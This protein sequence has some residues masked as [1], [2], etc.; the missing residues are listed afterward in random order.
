GVQNINRIKYKEK[1]T[2]KLGNDIEEVVELVR[3][4][5]VLGSRFELILKDTFYVPSFGR[6]LISLSCLD[7]H[8]FIF[9]FGETKINLMLNSQIIGYGSL[10]DR[11]YKFDLF[12]LTISDN[13]VV[14]FYAKINET[15]SRFKHLEVKYPIVKYLVKDGS[16]MVEHIDTNSIVV[17]PLIN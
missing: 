6:N 1:G 7:K 4:V 9:T 13:N 15:S 14:V 3:D 10:V 12:I 8:G 2:L 5:K 16:V 17:D 11:L